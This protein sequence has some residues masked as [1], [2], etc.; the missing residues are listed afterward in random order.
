MET[1]P[2]LMSEPGEAG[3]AEDG[4]MSEA[5]VE[6]VPVPDLHEETDLPTEQAAMP[7]TPDAITYKTRAMLSFR[8]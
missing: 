8:F 6:V 4:R 2:V 1:S 7:G 3:A 5:V